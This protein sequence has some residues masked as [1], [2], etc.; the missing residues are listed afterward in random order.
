MISTTYDLRCET[1]YFAWRKIRFVSAGFGLVD[2]GTKWAVVSSLGITQNVGD[3]EV[4]VGKKLRKRAA[5]SMKSL[6]RVNL[7]AGS[8]GAVSCVDARPNKGV[9]G[10]ATKTVASAE[11]ARHH[12]PRANPRALIEVNHVL[13]RHADAA[14]RNRLPDRIR[15]IGAMDSIECAREVHGAR[16]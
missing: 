7:C 9:P 4:A 12:D 1:F 15:F 8:T 11:L 3:L 16:A 5:K 2:A 10:T 13:V 6:A 14:R